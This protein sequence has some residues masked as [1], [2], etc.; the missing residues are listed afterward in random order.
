LNE[1]FN[2]TNT[3][4]SNTPSVF[5]SVAANTKIKFKLA[6]VGPNGQLTTGIIRTQTTVVQFTIQNKGQVQ[7]SMGTNQAVGDDPW[8]TDKYLNIWVCNMEG[9][10]SFGFIPDLRNATTYKDGVVVHY[11]LFGRNTGIAHKEQG[12]TCTHEVGHWLNCFHI[13]NQFNCTDSDMC[14]DTPTQYYSNDGCPSFPHSSC[15]NSSDM[16]MNYM[17]YT[18]DECQNL[19]TND[20]KDRMRTLFEP[21]GFR[22]TI[23]NNNNALQRVTRFYNPQGSNQEVTLK[24]I[25]NG[26]NDI[27]NTSNSYTP[28]FVDDCDKSGAISW[29]IVNSTTGAD[30]LIDGENASVRLTRFPATCQLEATIPRYNGGTKV[31]TYSFFIEL[32]MPNYVLSPNPTSDDMRI[33][34]K[35]K[36]SDTQLLTVPFSAKVYNF[37]NQLVRSGQGNNGLLIFDVVNLPIGNYQVV[38]E[39]RGRFVTKHVNI[40]R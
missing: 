33:Q 21:G 3:D 35:T 5:Q 26:Q 1:D 7:S 9:G 39:N 23:V 34:Q 4:A 14:D 18:Y 25:A 17:D 29:R 27:G 16:F 24:T 30:V 2:R 11:Q 22:Y 28:I 36:V 6:C 12:R 32:P 37:S 10:Y 20:Q 15:N 8:P 19:F 13:Y 31:E 40:H 38:I